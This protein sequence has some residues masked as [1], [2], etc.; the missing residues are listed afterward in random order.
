MNVAEAGVVIRQRTLLEVVD[1]AFRFSMSLG[2]KLYLRLCAY[3]LLPALGL[4][5]LLAFFTDTHAFWVWMFAFTLGTLLQGVFTIASGRL[6]FE[7]DVKAGVV[8]RQYLRRLWPYLWALFWTRLLLLVSS[9]III[10]PMLVGPRAAFVHEAVL[11]EGA[12]AREGM[13]RAGRF[14]WQDASFTFGLIIVSITLTLFFVGAGEMLGQSIVRDV[15]QLGEPLGRIQVDY[16]SVYS[17]FG[18]F[19]SVPLISTA[20]FLS[21]IDARTKRDAWDVQVRFMHIVARDA[22]QVS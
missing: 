1:L 6:M 8:A 4:T 5:C 2:G 21:Y 19:L 7:R 9:L 20:R 17:L 22:E 16:F 11:L 10:G 15:L 12:G 14:G 13:K 18:Y 3:F